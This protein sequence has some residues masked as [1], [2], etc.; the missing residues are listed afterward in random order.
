MSILGVF[1]SYYQT[2]LLKDTPPSNIAWIGSIQYCLVFFPAFVAGRLF[3]LGYWPPVFLGCSALLVTA[4]FLIGQCHEYWQFLL[5]QGFAVGVR[6]FIGLV[7]VA[8]LC[9][10]NR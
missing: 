8:Y 1:Q 6:A 2:G 7:A 5:C 4:T 3:D 10:I 9:I